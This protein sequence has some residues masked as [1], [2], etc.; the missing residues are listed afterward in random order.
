MEKIE[1]K[2]FDIVKF[3]NTNHLIKLSENSNNKLIDKIK[4][5]FSDI[6]QHLFLTSFYSYVNYDYKKDYVIDLDEIWD[7]LGFQQKYNAKLLLEKQFI[8]NIDYK[9]LDAIKSEPKKGSGGHNIKK[10]MMTVKTFKSFC[11]KASTKKAD[12]IHEYFIKLEEIIYETINDETNE[13]KEKFKIELETQ[14][15]NLDKE[16]EKEKQILREK[17]LLEQFPKNTQCIYYG[18]IDEKSTKNETLIKFG[19]SND[20]R[21]RVN[22]HKKTY[23]NFRLINVF[24]VGNKIQ[25]ENAM[26]TNPT[27]KSKRRNILID[28]KNYTELLAIDDF[29]F[30]HI[31]NMIKNI[32]SEYEYNVE[33]YNKLLE[34]NNELEILLNESIEKNKVLTDRNTFLEDKFSVNLSPKEKNSKRKEG[35]IGMTTASNIGYLLYA[36]EFKKDTFKCGITRYNDLENK[37]KMF[38]S[39]DPEGEM[40]YT[41]K[42][43]FPFSEKIMTF[44]L[45]ERLTK[46]GNDIYNGLSEDIKYIFEI[47][48]KIEEHIIDKNI[49]LEDMLKKFNNEIIINY[50]EIV[51][52][53]VPVVRKGKRAIDQINPANGEII[54]SYESIE[55]AGKSLGLTTG[56]A[57]GI[58]LRNRTLCKGFL[59]KYAGIS[60]EDQY[61]EQPIIKICC[62]TGEKTFFKNIALASKDCGISAIGLKNRIL[63]KIH[64]NDHHWVFD[65]DAS[66]YSD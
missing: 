50:K 55:K 43:S 65:K 59:F 12:E 17:T 58:A 53:E 31:D 15:V 7:W 46:I 26:K 39:L 52:S 22:T 47:V 34:R 24:K 21:E 3:I 27:L 48:S 56:T 9:L 63:T 16:K 44:L 41:I 14:K 6:Q 62:N 61:T 1:L 35:Q 25:I 45:K 57:V 64:V 54:A 28:N 13:L 19:N 51:D 29:T 40:K 4:N 23:T 20:L 42:I 11:L 8:E 49:S 38:Q 30:E 2:D 10:Y 32:I 37:I 33:N 18:I 5:N 66:H 60:Q 36:F